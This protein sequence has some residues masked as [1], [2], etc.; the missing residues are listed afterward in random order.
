MSELPSPSDES[1]VPRL[2]TGYICGQNCVPYVAMGISG[3]VVFT[4]ISI[5]CKLW[6]Q[7]RRKMTD[8]QSPRDSSLSLSQFT[9]D[10]ND[11]IAPRFTVISLHDPLRLSGSYLNR[12]QS[13]RSQPPAYAFLDMPPQYTD[14]FPAGQGEDASLS[15]AR[16][17]QNC[18]TAG[19]GED[20]RLNDNTVTV[21]RL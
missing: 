21:T 4:M 12:F 19:V 20:S 18:S 16:P 17:D 2:S 13:K 5:G 11:N 6:V 7:K 15:L 14:L 8:G 3:V 1:R 9:I 10:E